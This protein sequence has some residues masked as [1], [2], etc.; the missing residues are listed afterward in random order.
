M[1]RR[2][3]IYISALALSAALVA[4]SDDDPAPSES[5]P[6]AAE[7]RD[8][9][10]TSRLAAESGG[11]RPVPA[12]PQGTVADIPRQV[13]ARSARL[14]AEA[15]PGD[16]GCFAEAPLVEESVP[17]VDCA[18]PHSAERYGTLAMDS[19]WPDDYDEYDKGTENFDRWAAWAGP[20]C[21]RLMQQVNGSDPI[22]S[23]LGLD[24]ATVYPHTYTYN[25]GATP[26][27][28][29]W[30]AGDRNTY[31][32]SFTFGG[33]EAPGI[34]TPLLISPE[35]PDPLSICIGYEDGAWP[36]VPCSE[37]H[38]RE[39]VFFVNATG[40]LDQAFIDSVDPTAVT[41]EQYATLDEV[42]GSAEE[43]VVGAARDDL[44]FFGDVHPDYWGDDAG[45]YPINCGLVPT[46][47]SLDLVGSA[48]GVGDGDLELVP[49]AIPAS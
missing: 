13:V 11:D 44:L 36:Q 7:A 29:E 39:E 28:Q 25:V 49:T 22:A 21:N 33:H 27:R 19:S 40:V 3:L 5:D 1:R 2:A 18:G 8:A 32:V 37:Q 16:F 14:D 24:E 48:L 10:E 46:D 4:C 15:V 9:H 45:W 12:L 38:W 34:W 35:R 20:A 43:A 31:C 47:P 17:E 6:P 26:D 30:E 23:A 42:C 41:D